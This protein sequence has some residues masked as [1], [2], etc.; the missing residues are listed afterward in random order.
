M[1]NIQVG[2]K[3]EVEIRLSNNGINKKYSSRVLDVLG[4]K[5]FVLDT[6]Q[7]GDRI[8]EL[9]KGSDCDFVIY[10][11]EGIFRY[12]GQII[13]FISGTENG[14][15]FNKSIIVLDDSGH[16]LQR[17]ENFRFNCEIE[18]KFTELGTIG[19]GDSNRGVIIDLSAGGV[20]FLSNIE[21][22]KGDNISIEVMLDG[23]ILFLSTQVIYIDDVDSDE[24]EYQ[25]RCKFTD[26]L[27]TDKDIII[28][29]VLDVQRDALKKRKFSE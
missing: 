5:N 23:N 12:E 19:F 4:N 15:K 16:K 27:D 25:Y 20:K 22:K 14:K 3:V 1:E 2:N 9:P 13:D 26:L 24:F 7:R 11:D 17:R 21:L 28:Q 8:I 18:M 10:T 29:Y 6:I